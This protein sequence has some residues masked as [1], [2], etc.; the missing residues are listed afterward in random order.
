MNHGRLISGGGWLLRRLFTAAESPSKSPDLYRMLSALGKTGG[1]VSETLDN[2]TMKGKA[3]KTEE[4]LRYVQEL[5]RY[6]RFQHALEIIEWMEMRKIDSS[7]N[8]YAVQLDLVSKTK[9]VVAAEEFFSGLPPPA[10]NKFTYC[11]L[12]NC[13][14]KELMK[15]KALSHFEKM[16]ELG[17]VNSLA[18]SNLMSLYM[19]SGEPQKVPHLVQLMKMRSLPLCSFT[20]NIWMN[21]CASLGDLDGVERVYEEMKTKDRIGWQTY[22]NL[23]AISVKV[24]DF[25]KAEMMLKELEK[26]VKPRQR[27]AYHWLLSL[28]AGT[29]N[30]GEVH[31]V[32]N[33]LKSV[34]PVTN[35][36]YLAMLSNLRRL[37]DI[38]GLTK[39]FKEW[40][41]SCVS[42][43]V[44]LAGVCVSAYLGQNMVEEAALVFEGASRRSKSPLF[45]IEEMFILYFLEKRQLDA[46]VRHLEAAISEV[47]GDE[48]HPS[49][50]VVGAFLKYYEEDTG[51]DGVD[52]LCKIL[53]AKNFDDSWI[54]TCINEAKASPETD[55]RL[56]EDD[57]QNYR[58]QEN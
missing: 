5:R 7:R 38:E 48:W 2:H 24:K 35:L 8:N 54:K 33:S 39:C 47:K 9:G 11:A 17:Y 16:D 36:S 28:Y 42:Y 23:A 20:Y 19:R 53:K 50:Q 10:K 43:D 31:R 46:A 13:Y 29:G 14:C 55:P 57:P 37:N 51:M 27:D 21:S 52:E 34:S 22:S 3:I 58:A 32:W 25:E 6:R 30:L 56:K 12:L 49:P 4:L 44:R 1:S 41:A 45:R 26:R 15:D 40:E 18:F